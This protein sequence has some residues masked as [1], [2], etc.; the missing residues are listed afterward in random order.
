MVIKIV[1]KLSLVF[2]GDSG[3]IVS[4]ILGSVSGMDAVAINIA[5]LAGNIV[6]YQTAIITLILANAF[7]LLAKT[8]YSFIY[9]SRTFALSFLISVLLLIA[10]SFVGLMI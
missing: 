6:T 9:G 8:V 3:F 10:A 5:Q 2:F 1:T 4:N 7:N